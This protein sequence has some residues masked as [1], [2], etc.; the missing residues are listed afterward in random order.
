MVSKDWNFTNTSTA[1]EGEGTRTTAPTTAATSSGRLSPATAD[2]ESL[3]QSERA[4][5][6]ESVG[7]ERECVCCSA[8]GGSQVPGCENFSPELRSERVPRGGEQTLFWKK[9]YQ[10]RYAEG[11]T[12]N[13]FHNERRCAGGEERTRRFMEASIAV[14]RC[15]QQQRKRL[16]ISPPPPAV[17][18]LVL[19][20]SAGGGQNK[21]GENCPWTVVVPLPS[22]PLPKKHT[23]TSPDVAEEKGQASHI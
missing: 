9:E 3:Q 20:G 19:G 4:R 13:T 21:Q 10:H 12:A 18:G 17:P 7:R 22:P 6:S 23:F 16:S 1:E 8:Q 14:E 2:G 15:R 5:E 11:V